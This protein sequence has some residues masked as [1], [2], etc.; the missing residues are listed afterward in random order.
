[1]IATARPV[2]GGPTGDDSHGPGWSSRR[3]GRAGRQVSRVRS[4]AGWGGGQ[5]VCGQHG[6]NACAGQAGRSR[7]L[8]GNRHVGGAATRGWMAAAAGGTPARADR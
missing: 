2:T 6:S 1:M 4:Q 7:T 3:R 5:G 8:E